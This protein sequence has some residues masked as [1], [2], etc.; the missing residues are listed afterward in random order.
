MYLTFL[1]FVFLQTDMESCDWNITFTCPSIH[2]TFTRPNPITC[3]L[4]NS[5]FFVS[6]DLLVFFIGKKYFK[7]SISLGIQKISLDLLILI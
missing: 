6:L 1:F 3:Y 5:E 4:S 7:K 2:T